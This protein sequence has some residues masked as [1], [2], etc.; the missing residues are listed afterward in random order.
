MKD[1]ETK[2][3][4]VSAIDAA[5]N[6]ATKN[7]QR[8]IDSGELPADGTA[9]ATEAAA[10]RPRLSDAQKLER[11]TQ[12]DADRQTRKAERAT[13]RDA[14]RAERDASK[15]PAHMAKVTK[16]AAKLPAL[17]DEAQLMFNDITSNFARDQINA[18]ALHLAHFNRVKATERALNQKLEAGMNV[19]IVSG[20]PK[21]VGLEGTVSKAQR[22]R[23]Y[24][25]V[26]GSKKPIYVFTSDV[27]VIQ[28][29]EKTGT[30][31]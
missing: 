8:K 18:I 6:K 10:K 25:N 1:K 3:T 19:R 11:Q 24:V 26:E 28:S 2:A 14:K 17:N 22:I 20:D 13:A 27:E 4:D 5:I 30:A 23:A 12:R 15:V 29:N 16:A 7:K 21:F 31:E 9:P